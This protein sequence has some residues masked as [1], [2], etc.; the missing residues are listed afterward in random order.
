VDTADY[1]A[2]RAHGF[3][4]DN[5]VYP[6]DVIGG[7]W[8]GVRRAAGV[9]PGYR[10]NRG[11]REA[12]LVFPDS[13][14]GYRDCGV[15]PY[16]GPPLNPAGDALM[17]TCSPLAPRPV[18]AAYRNARYR[19]FADRYSAYGQEWRLLD[20]TTGRSTLVVDAPSI[21]QSETNFAWAPDGRSIMISTALLPLRGP[22]SAQRVTHRMAAEIDLQSGRITVVAPDSLIVRGWDPR[23]GVVEFARHSAWFN[24]NDRTPRIYFQKRHGRWG[25][26]SAP[27]DAAIRV[28]LDQGPNQ[29]PRLVVSD[30]AL[31]P[32]RTLLDPNPRL[33]AERTFGRV[34]LFHWATKGGKVYVGGLYYPP[35]YVPGR[36]YPLVLQTH[37]FDST[38]F[39]PDGVFTTGAAAQPLASAGIV[40]LQGVDQVAGDKTGGWGTPEEGPM[41]QGIIEAAIDSLDHRGLIDRN[42]VAMEGFSR[43]CFSTLYFL[44]HSSYPIAAADVTDGVD[45]SYMQYLVYHGGSDDENMNSGRPWGETHAHWLERAPGF[46]L[47]RIKT[48]M[49]LTAIGPHTVLQEWEPYAGLLAQGKP[50]ELV[51]IPDGSHILVKPWERMTS[52][53]GAVDWYRFWLQGYEDPDSSKADQYAR[54]RRMRA[55]RDSTTAQSTQ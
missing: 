24:V 11:G 55:Q 46:R 47:D 52:Q 31:R 54:W 10:I 7:D 25:R 35:D 36:R 43:T 15:D 44:T 38:A 14:D 39:L 23:T 20:L 45:F 26:V 49:R 21:P 9:A 37:G 5:R 42:K 22:D 48:P 40:V 8:R 27:R 19:L 12:A 41:T 18:W 2:M 29:P 30:S 34:E 6:S 13:T 4:V 1:S 51:Y 53:Q 3:V 17:I 28:V 33:L 16:L 32:I 50:A